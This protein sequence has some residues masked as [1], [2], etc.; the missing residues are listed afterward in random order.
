MEKKKIIFWKIPLSGHTFDLEDLPHWLAG[1][2]IKVIFKDNEFA[3]QIPAKIIGENYKPVRK[4]AEKQLQLI[5]GAG[6]LLNP[7]FR[8][9]ALSN[10]LC[11]IDEWGKVIHT[12]G[13]I[14]TAEE[15]SKA[16][17]IKAVVGGVPQPDPRDRAALPF[18]NATNH[19]TLANDALIIFARPELTW[20]ELYLLYEIVKGDVGSIMLT[21]K[22]ISKK[23]E[24]LFSRTANSYSVLRVDG[25]HGKDQGEPPSNPMSKKQAESLIRDLIVSWLRYVDEK[26]NQRMVGK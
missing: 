14:G 2:S 24:K 4:L 16:G 10:R 22:W 12:V 5:N 9:V 17:T 3:L 21:K 6:R 1:Y 19:S 8:P 26:T 25:R 13:I 11:G 23:K 15:R 7:N 20:T 18:L